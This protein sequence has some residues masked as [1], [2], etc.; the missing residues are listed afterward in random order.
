MSR[1]VTVTLTE[2]EAVTAA[3]ALTRLLTERGGHSRSELAAAQ[4]A[5]DKIYTPDPG[6]I[7]EE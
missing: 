2:L 7:T 1:K 3:S 6:Q 4:R 5:R